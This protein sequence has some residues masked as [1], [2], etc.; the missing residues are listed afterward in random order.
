[1]TIESRRHYVY[2]EKAGSV[3]IE[4]TVSHDKPK[5]LPSQLLS[6]LQVS[7]SPF[8]VIKE[9]CAHFNLPQKTGF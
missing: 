3:A 2:T 8:T 1:M 5:C 6:E 7:A 9:Q 4:M